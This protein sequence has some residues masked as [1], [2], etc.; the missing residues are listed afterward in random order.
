MKRFKT[1]EQFIAQEDRWQNELTNLRDILNGTPLYET[2]KWGAPSY[3]FKG[4]NVVGMAAFK[5]CFGL[6]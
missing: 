4:K 3:T 2:I 6:S 1:V 5:E